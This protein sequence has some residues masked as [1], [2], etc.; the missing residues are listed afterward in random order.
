MEFEEAVFIVRKHPGAVL[1]R[2]ENGSFF[3]RLID[4]EIINRESPHR[5]EYTIGRI[6]YIKAAELE[7]EAELE[8]SIFRNQVGFCHVFWATQKRILKDKYGIDWKTPAEEN[9]QNCYD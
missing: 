2:D 4:G 3:V 8:N 9:P 7:A 6:D 5:E 1:T